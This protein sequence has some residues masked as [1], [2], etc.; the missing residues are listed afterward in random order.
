MEVIAENRKARFEYFILEEFEAGMVLLST[1]VKS[2]RERK[3][4]ISDAYVIEKDGEIWLHNMHIAEYKAANKKKH[5]PKR[6]RKLLL[7]K[8]EINKLIG[9]IKI[10]G[11]AVVPLLTYFN[12]KGLAKTKIAIVKGKK[13]YDKRVT[14]KQREWDREKNRLYKNNL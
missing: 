5:K 1:E 6:E 9:K 12:N 2:L 8:K 7:H 3:A 10:A 13:L 4:N 14:I 11:V